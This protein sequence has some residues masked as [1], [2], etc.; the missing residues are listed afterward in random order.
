[1]TK[2]LH[3]VLFPKKEIE[4]K[5]IYDHLQLLIEKFII[6]SPN[7]PHKWDIL[8]LKDDYDHM[9]FNLVPWNAT[10]EVCNVIDLVLV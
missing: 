2:Q 5:K 3:D 6:H 9:T 7:A 1:M 4:I 8:G 10:K